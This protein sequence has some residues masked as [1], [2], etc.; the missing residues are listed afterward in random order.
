MM[1]EKVHLWPY[2]KWALLWFKRSTKSEVRQGHLSKA[3]RL[4]RPQMYSYLILKIVMGKKLRILFN[5]IGDVSNIS[6]VFVLVY[7]ISIKDNCISS[8]KECFLC[9]IRIIKSRRMRWAGHVA[10]MGE[11]RNAY[12]L[13]VEKTEG[14]RPLRRPRRRWVDNIK[15]DL[16]EIGLGRCGLDWSSSG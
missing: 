9:I 16:L 11:K 14:K 3:P 6:S 12:R 13:L 5:W 4:H 15:M 8:I 7:I 2:V 10:R 1:H